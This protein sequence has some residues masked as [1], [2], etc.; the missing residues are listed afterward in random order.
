MPQAAA[1]GASQDREA[2][3]DLL[4]TT[5][6]YG[7]IILILTSLPLVFGAKWFL[8]LWI[9]NSYADKTTLVL[10]IMVIAN[11][12][13][14]LGAPYANIA[15][16]VGAQKQIFLSPVAEALVNITISVV[17]TAYYGVIGVVIGTLCGAC[18]S[19]G[20]HYGYSLNRTTQIKVKDRRL[21]IYA[22][23]RPMLSVIPA[24]CL[25]LIYQQMSL[26]PSLEFIFLFMA[27]VFSCLLLWKYA[28][29]NTERTKLWAAIYSKI[30]QFKA[31]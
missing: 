18:V 20:I 4:V 19:I 26:S 3:G 2:L 25:W 8:T 11:C 23:V 29:F 12:I 27:T 31:N 24:V 28:I 10:Q 15:L 5:T 9:G 1:I 6:R 22:V 30:N 16:A 13:R 7:A 14:Y 21:L 17:L